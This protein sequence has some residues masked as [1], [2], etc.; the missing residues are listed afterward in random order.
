MHVLESTAPIDVDHEPDTHAKHTCWLIAETLDEYVPATQVVH[1]V[2]VAADHDPALQFRHVPDASVAHVPGLQLIQK[3]TLLP[4]NVEYMPA[5]QLRQAVDTDA[6]M[7]DEYDPALHDKQEL[8]LGAPAVDEY[9]PAMQ[10]VHVIELLGD[11][12]P[13][14]QLMHVPLP[15]VDHDPA[16]HTT[17]AFELAPMVVK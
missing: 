4:T 5:G 11:H 10:L 13:A 17:H 12:V 15:L 3:F 9:V 8:E 1:V 7:D 2:A 14:L 16:L 6:A